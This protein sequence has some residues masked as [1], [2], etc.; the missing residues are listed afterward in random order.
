MKARLVKLGLVLFVSAAALIP[1]SAGWAQETDQLEMR[2]LRTFGF[3][4]GLQVQG[5]FSARVSGPGDLERVTLYLDGEPIGVD[6]ATPFRIDFNTGDFSAGEHRL[7]AEGTTASGRTL[8]GPERR[9]IF[10]TAE[11]GLETVSNY[12]LPIFVLIGVGMLLSY[13]LAARRGRRGHFRPGEY[14]AAGGAVCRRCGM[15][16]SRHFLA[17]N[18]L[19]GKLERCPHCGQW[20]IVARASAAALKQAEERF[21]ADSEGGAFQPST[22]EDDLLE[23]IKDS[24]FED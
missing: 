10:L 11:Q 9:L 23:R 2:L 13:V 12:L 8:V 17:P 24:R 1:F 14:G 20:A 4:A 21:A 16:F 15:P 3:Q 18:L 5:S 19:L 7:W 22:P 6:A